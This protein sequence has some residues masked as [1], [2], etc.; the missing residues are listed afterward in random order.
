MAEHGPARYLFSVLHV[1]IRQGS[2]DEAVGRLQEFIR[3]REGPQALLQREFERLENEDPPIQLDPNATAS[4]RASQFYVVWGV[5]EERLRKMAE[6]LRELRNTTRDGL[7]D[8]VVDAWV[9]R[10]ADLPQ[11]DDPSGE[12]W[13]LGWEYGPGSGVTPD[14]RGLQRY[15][16]PRFLAGNFPG[17]LGGIDANHVLTGGPAARQGAGITILIIEPAWRLSHENLPPNLDRA[18]FLGWLHGNGMNDH[19]YPESHGTAVL[20]ILVGTGANRY[21][22]LYPVPHNTP[23]GVLGICPSATVKGIGIYPWWWQTPGIPAPG[24]TVESALYDAVHRASLSPGDIVLVETTVRDDLDKRVPVE[25]SPEAKGFITDLANR[26]VIVVEAAG[27]ENQWLSDPFYNEPPMDRHPSSLVGWTNPFDPGS[28][29][30]NAIVVGAGAPPRGTRGR[31]REHPGQARAKYSNH[32]DRVD[33]QGWGYDIMTCGY[34]HL[35][36]GADPDRWYTDRFSGTSGAAAMVAGVLACVMGAWKA[37]EPT[38]FAPTRTYSISG[39]GIVKRAKDMLRGVSYP[40]GSA[41]N[42]PAQRSWVLPGPGVPDDRI[43]YL[44]DLREL[45]P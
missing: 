11:W 17:V 1:L 32:G 19:V 22:G 43:G 18:T 6:Q 41:L 2:S 14:F 7:R 4:L 30:E 12:D 34:G 35:Q 44:P 33:V 26:G 38:A 45:I 39:P 42:L 8:I 9:S 36:G 5:A 29:F 25:W 24:K 27:N 28:L 31:D 40:G 37:G 23:T 10:P 15:R 16:L 21:P 3:D 20:G 13:P